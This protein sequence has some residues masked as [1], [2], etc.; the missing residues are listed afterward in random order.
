MASTVEVIVKIGSSFNTNKPELGG[1]RPEGKGPTRAT[2]AASGASVRLS[3]LSSRLAEV[4]ASLGSGEVFD[5][6]Q[7]DRIKQAIADGKFRV[8]TDAVADKLI[9]N[10]REMLGQ[11]A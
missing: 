4:E 2:E 1:V 7:V 8:N 9:A 3:D 10:V 5:T 6:Q 11:K